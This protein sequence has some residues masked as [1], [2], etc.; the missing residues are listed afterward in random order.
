MDVPL[1][2]LVLEELDDVVPDRVLGGEPLGPR[3][4]LA[5]R[6]SSLLDREAEET[7]ITEATSCQLES[8]RLKWGSAKV[9]Y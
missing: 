8:R 1:V 3:E 9:V 5:R 4:D 2:E 7:N 6:E